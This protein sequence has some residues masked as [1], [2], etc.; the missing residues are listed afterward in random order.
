MQ[1]A[2]LALY[3]QRGGTESGKLFGAMSVM[4]SLCSQIIGP[5]LFGVTFLK[6]VRT[7]PTAIF[8]LAAAAVMLSF[9]V[10]LFVR[11]PSETP[12][13]LGLHTAEETAVDVRHEHDETLVD[14]DVPVIMIEDMGKVA[15]PS[16]S[17][18]A[19]PTL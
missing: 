11:L 8:F 3:T 5:A 13:N 1:S 17:V 4:Q 15:S 6:S 2:A 16:S 10:L 12:T 9:I 7:F 19:S 18:Q 14:T